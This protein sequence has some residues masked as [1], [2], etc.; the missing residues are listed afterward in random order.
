MLI[1]NVQAAALK[2]SCLTK[3]FGLEYVDY[4]WNRS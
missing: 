2:D 4:D 3:I 1:L